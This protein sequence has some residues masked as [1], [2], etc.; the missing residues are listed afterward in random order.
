MYL[1]GV[2]LTAER[3]A[4]PNVV[5]QVITKGRAATGLDGWVVLRQ[6]HIGWSRPLHQ[7]TTAISMPQLAGPRI[8]AAMHSWSPGLEVSTSV[9]GIPIM[10]AGCTADTGL[11]W[12][13]I[14][15][16]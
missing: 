16:R 9:P 13:G 14:Q 5:Q 3:H 6:L 1:E 10:L 7:Y 15:S 4:A 2:V 11:S 12:K 8:G